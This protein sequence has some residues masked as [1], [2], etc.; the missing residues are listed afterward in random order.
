MFSGRII[1]IL[2]ILAIGYFLGVKFPQIAGRLG[3][4]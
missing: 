4:A 2:V 3:I 1:T